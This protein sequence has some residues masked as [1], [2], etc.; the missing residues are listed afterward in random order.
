MAASLGKPFLLALEDM[1]HLPRLGCVSQWHHG[2][3]RA[4]GL[5]TKLHC[6]PLVICCMQASVFTFKEVFLK[7][8]S[9]SFHGIFI[10][11][12]CNY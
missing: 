7:L 8:E 9:L 2:A 1:D 3:A 5:A 10:Y 12:M 11:Y 6:T 4:L